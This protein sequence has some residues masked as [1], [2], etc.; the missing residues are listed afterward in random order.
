VNSVHGWATDAFSTK[1][2]TTHCSTLRHTVTHAFVSLAVLHHVLTAFWQQSFN[3]NTFAVK[4][5]ILWN[6]QEQIFR[7]PRRRLQL[8]FNASFVAAAIN[9]ILYSRCAS[10]QTQRIINIM[11]RSL[12]LRPVTFMGGK[13][14]IAGLTW[15]MEICHLLLSTVRVA[16]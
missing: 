10:I 14:V 13:L 16:Q 5:Q 9:R 15:T 7:L 12:L 2:A 3:R 4:N 6:W 1:I 11:A 8:F